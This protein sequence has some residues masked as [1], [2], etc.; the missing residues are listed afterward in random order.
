[1]SN[2][3]IFTGNL[4]LQI[5][6]P[7]TSCSF[8]LY[9]YHLHGLIDIGEKHTV[10]SLLGTEEVCPMS[11]YGLEHQLALDLSKD[12]EV[13]GSNVTGINF[14][15]F[16]KTEINLFD[17]QKNYKFKHFQIWKFKFSIF[18]Y[19]TLNDNFSIEQECIPVGCI[20]AAHRPYAGVCFRGGGCVSAPGGGCLL[21]GGVCSRGCL[22]WSCLLLGVSALG[23]CLLWG[24]LLWGV[25]ALGGGVC[26]W[27]V[28]AWGVSAPGGC[29]LPGGVVSQQALRQ[30]P[31]P[32]EQN[33]RQV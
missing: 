31:P 28:S 22:L 7:V 19:K 32:C 13:D 27:G 16:W 25:S 11:M 33:D 8:A 3:H 21:L 23:R 2:K 17:F 26:S 14:F 4:F 20:L 15:D 6:T 18:G 24:C 9:K 1:M 10:T 30:T 12:L 5:S 29:L